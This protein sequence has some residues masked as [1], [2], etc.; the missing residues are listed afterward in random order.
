MALVIDII[1][2]SFL[3]IW[4]TIGGI[5]AIIFAILGFSFS[6]QLICFIATSVILMAICYP[7]VKKIIKKTV[8][9]TNTMEKNY[10][11]KVFICDKDV[12]K[13]ATIKY[14]GIYWTV[15]NE[16]EFIHKGDKVKIIGIDGNRLVIKKEEN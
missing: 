13:K 3:F 15:I 10:I 9:V 14:E 4:F 11:G 12:D 5:I 1:T 6:T 7:Y 16:G 2:S 8:P